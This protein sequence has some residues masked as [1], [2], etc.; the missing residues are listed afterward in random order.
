VESKSNNIPKI[1]QQI[2]IDKNNIIERKMIVDLRWLKQVQHTVMDM[3]AVG[4][5]RD[6]PV[7]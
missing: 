4:F 7:R 1:L 3:L 6:F 2:T 5:K